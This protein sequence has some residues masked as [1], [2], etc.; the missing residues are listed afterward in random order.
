MTKNRSEERNKWR[1]SGVKNLSSWL[2]IQSEN[3][4]GFSFRETGVQAERNPSRI[5]SRRAVTGCRKRGTL[6]WDNQLDLHWWLVGHLNTVCKLYS[7]VTEQLFQQLSPLL[8][9]K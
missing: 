9:W 8:T 2:F 7:R 5:T 1:K 3:E 6:S 4:A